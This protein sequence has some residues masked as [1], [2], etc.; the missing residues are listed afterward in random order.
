MGFWQIHPEWTA[1]LFVVYATN[2]VKVLV[3][4]PSFPQFF[5]RFSTDI[6]LFNS[7]ISESPGKF[8]TVSTG[9]REPHFL[10]SRPD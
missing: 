9:R 2:F 4:Y 7:Q 10:R 3:D 8:S 1:E 5:H 6:A